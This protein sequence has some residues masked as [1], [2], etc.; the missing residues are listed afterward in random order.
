MSSKGFVH[1]FIHPS[2]NVIVSEWVGPATIEDWEDGA[3]IA[4]S[5]FGPLQDHHRLIDIRRYT[6]ALSQADFQLMRERLSQNRI[7]PPSADIRVAI[8]HRKD[9]LVHSDDWLADTFAPRKVA[10]FD[11]EEACLAWLLAQAPCLA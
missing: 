4:F 10:Y 7:A 2:G 6:S 5:D 11:N 3:L 9:H 1:F 8:L